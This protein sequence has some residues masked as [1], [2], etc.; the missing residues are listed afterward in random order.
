M[1][2]TSGLLE[3]RR[4]WSEAI[5]SGDTDLTHKDWYE[6]KKKKKTMQADTSKSIQPTLA[7]LALE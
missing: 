5:A 4:E 1:A 2:D 3:T 7:S 6:Q